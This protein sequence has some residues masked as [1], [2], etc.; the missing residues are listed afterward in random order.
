MFPHLYNPV[1]SL[2]GPILSGRTVLQDVLDKNAP[3]HLSIAQPA[4][5]PSTPDNADSQGLACCSEE[6]HSEEDTNISMFDLEVL[7]L[8]AVVLFLIGHFIG[9]L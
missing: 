7:H 6:L 5:H 8:R 9:R 1:P 3:H 4:A 2:Q